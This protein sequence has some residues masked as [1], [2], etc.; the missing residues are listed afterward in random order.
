MSKLQEIQL[1]MM[2]N[3]DLFGLILLPILVIFS[4]L[5]GMLIGL[6][7]KRP[8]IKEEVAREIL[9]GFIVKALDKNHSHYEKMKKKYL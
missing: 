7:D 3:D 1:M 2:F 6:T 4:Y 9:E 5:L 8:E